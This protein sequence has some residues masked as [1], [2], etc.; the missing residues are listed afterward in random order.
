MEIGCHNTSFRCIKIVLGNFIHFHSKKTNLQPVFNSVSNGS[1]HNSHNSDVTRRSANHTTLTQ[2][3]RHSPLR[4]SHNTHTTVTSLAAPP[5]KTH[6][7]VTSLAAPPI[8][9]HTTVTSLSAPPI[10]TPVYLR[11]RLS[12]SVPQLPPEV[13]DVPSGSGTNELWGE[14]EHIV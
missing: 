12:E 4:Q 9:T 1:E 11:P 10:V 5:N 13:V 2:Q 6:T 3:W 7:T 14:G 8:N